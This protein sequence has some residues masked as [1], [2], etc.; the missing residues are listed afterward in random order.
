ML[1]GKYHGEKAGK[2]LGERGVAILNTMARKDLLSS[3]L[4][5]L[6]LICKSFLLGQ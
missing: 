2:E 4:S 5:F 3:L 6:F 1:E